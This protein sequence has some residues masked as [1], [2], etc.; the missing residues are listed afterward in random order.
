MAAIVSQLGF[1]ISALLPTLA[2]NAVWIAWPALVSYG[3]MALVG[4]QLAKVSWRLND[5]DRARRLQS[6]AISIPFGY[7]LTFFFGQIVGAHVPALSLFG[8]PFLFMQV[9]GLVLQA[10]GC[11][12]LVWSLW[13]LSREANWAISN[14]SAAEARIERMKQRAREN[15][16][17][18]QS[19]REASQPFGGPIP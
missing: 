8:V 4:F 2:P 14:A 5:V 13:S 18:T 10:W 6:A 7:G 17:Q 9:V 11:M 12:Y 16:E 1:V 15:Y 3:G 19:E